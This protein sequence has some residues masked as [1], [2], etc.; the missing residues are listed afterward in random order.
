M[1]KK[2]YNGVQRS[3]GGV[4]F[5]WKSEGFQWSVRSEDDDSV[6]DTDL[7]TVVTSCIKVQ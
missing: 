3:S 7:L 6:S 5:S 1:S 4:Q 2:E